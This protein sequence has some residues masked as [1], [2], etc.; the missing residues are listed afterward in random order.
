MKTTY[1]NNQRGI[2]LVLPLLLVALVGT[3]VTAAVLQAG[4]AQQ[5]KQA[6][7]QAAKDK[8][9]LE[10]L[11]ERARTADQPST[12]PSATSA[13]SS[14]PTS[15]TPKPASTTT[16]RPTATTAAKPTPTPAPVWNITNPTSSTCVAGST[17]TVYGA[18]AAG[19][20][21]YNYDIETATVVGHLPYKAAQTGICYITAGKGWIQYGGSSYPNARYLRFTDVSLTAPPQ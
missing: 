15:T 11:A 21:I 3:V 5:E 1:L 16:P 10:Q 17:K 7:Q 8:T 13:T 6:A 18:V 19:A 2:A 4:K 14:S 20:P 9:T 12:N